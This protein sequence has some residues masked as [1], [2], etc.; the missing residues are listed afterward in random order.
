[1]LDIDDEEPYI[2]K[3][4]KE[5]ENKTYKVFLDGTYKCPFD[6]KHQDGEKKSLID[7]AKSTTIYGV[8]SRNRARHMALLTYMSGGE[9]DPTKKGIY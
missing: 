3:I 5:L 8:T 9:M 4:I 1:M 6:E 2:R 7:H